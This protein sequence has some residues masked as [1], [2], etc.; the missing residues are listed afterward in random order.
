V[1]N[2][3]STKAVRDTVFSSPKFP[4]LLNPDSLRSTIAQGVS[5]G[6]IAYT[7][8]NGSLYEPLLYNSE[9]RPADIEI[10]DDMF[11]V[12]GKTAEQYLASKASPPLGEVAIESADGAN[13]MVEVIG[14]ENNS[15][16]G[17]AK[18][19][20]ERRSRNQATP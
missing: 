11:I 10:S 19:I 3:W 8:K 12:T 15:Y 1:L 20:L 14:E 7:G 2:E 17:V 16:V 18:D 5:N 4:R 9:V 6:Q 13:E